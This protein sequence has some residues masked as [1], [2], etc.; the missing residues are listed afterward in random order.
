MRTLLTILL[1]SLGFMTTAQDD[2]P[3]VY[4]ASDEHNAFIVERADGTDTRIFGAYIPDLSR[5]WV[6]GPGWSPDGQYFAFHFPLTR[7]PNGGYIDPTTD[8]MVWLDDM[9][10]YET[11]HWE[12]SSDKLLLFGIMNADED[13]Y[14][15]ISV[16]LMDIQ[17]EKLLATFQS[18]RGRTSVGYNPIMWLETGVNFLLP[19]EA[20]MEAN[21]WYYRIIMMNDGTVLKE[22]ITS[23]EFYENF[24]DTEPNFLNSEF[25]SPSGRYQITA[26][27]TLTD[28]VTSIVQTFPTPDFGIDVPVNWIIADTKWHEGEEW[29]LLF[30]RIT[31]NFDEGLPRYM[32]SAK[33]DGTVFRELSMCGDAPAC[34]GWLPDNMDVEMLA[35]LAR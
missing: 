32:V 26:G 2:S 10:A 25:V 11:L 27:G 1:F 7:Y 21:S 28:T 34:V 4:Y 30:Y 8:E 22:P 23:E 24:V 16:W 29:V 13:F 5:S 14:P 3:Y 33:A 17:Q 6:Y 20:F 15:Y 35:P 18:R 19:E 12:P 9:W 31:G